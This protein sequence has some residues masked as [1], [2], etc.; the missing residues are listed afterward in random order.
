MRYVL[1][2]D[3]VGFSIGCDFKLISFVVEVEE[4]LSPKF[5]VLF[6]FVSR[7]KCFSL[8]FHRW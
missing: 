5:F 1:E 7:A 3:C 6:C 8:L 4:Y 2:Q